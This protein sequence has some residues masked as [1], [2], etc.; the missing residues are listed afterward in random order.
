M[1]SGNQRVVQALA[2]ALALTSFYAVSAVAQEATA[3]GEVRR[4]DAAAGKI[5]IKHGAIADLE[6]PA[7]TLVYHIDAALLA[8]IKPGDKVKF[9]AKREN[10]QYVITKISK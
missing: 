2:A 4:I 9:T 6:L 8:D 7:M 1:P 5:T 10:S 3:S